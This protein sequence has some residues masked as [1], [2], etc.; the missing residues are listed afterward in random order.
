MPEPFER[1][2]NKNRLFMIEADRLARINLTIGAFS[3][4]G[5]LGSNKAVY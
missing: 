1:Q 2:A 4:Y 5:S 3:D